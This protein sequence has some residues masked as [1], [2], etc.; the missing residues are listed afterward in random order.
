V[1]ALLGTSA[2]AAPVSVEAPVSAA[3][4]ACS[5]VMLALPQEIDSLGKRVTTSQ[6]TAAWGDPAAVVLSCG[7]PERGPS[8]DPCTTVGDVDWTAKQDEGEERWTLTAYGRVPRIEVSIDTSRVSSAAVA[9]AL[10]PAVALSPAQKYCA[11]PA[12]G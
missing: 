8:S 10:S 7:T 6:S 1:L 5:P 4:A 9:A 12:A 11:A 2:C 3:D